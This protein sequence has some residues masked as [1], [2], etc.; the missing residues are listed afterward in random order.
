M[1]V[2]MITVNNGQAVRAAARAGLGII[3]QPEILVRRDFETGSL[4]PL[5]TE[6]RLGE[7]PMWLVYYRDRRMTPRLSSFISFAIS[8]FGASENLD[9][10]RSSD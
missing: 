6:W 9:K 10:R 7:R 8:T 3:M 2:R 4:T 1:P 5:L